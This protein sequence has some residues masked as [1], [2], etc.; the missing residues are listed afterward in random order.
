MNN[1]LFFKLGGR[2]IICTANGH[3]GVLFDHHDFPDSP[4]VSGPKE[5]HSVLI[6]VF[7]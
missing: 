1:K 5:V 4:R 7:L 6:K 2:I 3:I